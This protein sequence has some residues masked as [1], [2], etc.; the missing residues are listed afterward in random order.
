M[1]LKIEHDVINALRV[2]FMLREKHI[3]RINDEGLLNEAKNTIYIEFKNITDDF[4]I[5]DINPNTK[6]FF[7]TLIDD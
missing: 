7:P 4:I 5:S 3:I 6:L 1:S 2:P